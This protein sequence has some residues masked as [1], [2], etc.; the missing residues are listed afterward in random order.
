MIGFTRAGRK[1]P[2]SRL[3]G[4]G[5]I[6]AG[7]G[8]LDSRTAEASPIRTSHQRYEEALAETKAAHSWSAY[9]LAGPK[10]WSSLVHPRVT[11]DVQTAIWKALRSDSPESSGWVHF[12]LWKQSLDPARFAR[13][14][15]R[16]APVL[17]RI[18]SASLAPQVTPP[19]TAATTATPD[20][21]PPLTQAQSLTP[22]V[23]EPGAWLLALGM[24][25]WGL[26]WRRRGR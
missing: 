26:W 24:A 2:V 10:V 17:N 23:P 19:T 20:T 21:S 4:I 6:A 16:V 8:V 11:P 5:L 3:I 22:V 14:H 1:L 15:H 9:L 12:L 18:S 25:G 13:N 7:W